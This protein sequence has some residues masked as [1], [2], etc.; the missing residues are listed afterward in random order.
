[1]SLKVKRVIKIISLLLLVF[2]ICI[3]SLA[4][5]RYSDFKKTLIVKIAN[6]ATSFIGQKVEIGDISFSTAGIN[7]YDISVKNPEEFIS[8]ELLRIKKLYLDMKYSD[9]VSRK[10]YFKKI[11]VYSPELTILRDQRGRM[12]ISE[13]LKDFFKRKPT[14]TYQIDELEMRSGSFDVNRVFRNENINIH[15]K[16]LS[17]NAG[18][19]TT[20]KGS[21]S[22]AGGNKIDFDGWAY[23]KD[24]PKRL[25]I[26]VSS[27]DI[28]LSPFKELLNKYR[29]NTE[30]TKSG[31]HLNIWGD[32]A[33]GLHIKSE[34]RI[35]E[36]GGSF[37]RRDA[38]EILLN[39][40][41]FFNIPDNLLS[42]EDC[43][44]HSDLLTV[45]TLKGEIKREEKDFVF[46]IL[47]KISKLDL[48]AFNFMKN[49]QVNG[50]I[51]SENLFIH[52][53]IK[54]HFP[55][56]SGTIKLRDG[57]F[58][59]KE[60]DI[61]AINA[62]LTF[63]PGRKMTAKAEAT[64][65][66]SRLKGY[67][68]NTSADANLQ[69]TATGDLKDIVFA[70]YINLS[71]VAIDIQK[72][73]KVHAESL[74]LNVKGNIKAK[75][76]SGESLV[77]IKV[78][79]YNK[80][81]IPRLHTKFLIK[82][83]GDDIA[84]KTLSMEGED[85]RVSSEL[86]TVSL[87]EREKKDKV[88]IKIEKLNASH[89]GKKA[90]IRDTDLRL[91]ISRGSDLIAGDLDFSIG[92][93]AFSGLHTGI[94]KGSGK[95]DNKNF[96]LKIPVAEVFHGKVRLTLQGRM[97][98]GPFPIKIVSNAEDIDLGKLS[99]E[100]MKITGMPYTVSGDLKSVVLE[101]TLQNTGSVEGSGKIEAENIAVLDKSIRTILRDVSLKG[102]IEF[103]GDDLDFNIDASDGKLS[104]DISGTVKKFAQKDRLLEMK[105]IQ[106]EVKLTDIRETFWEV[107]PYNLLYSGLGGFLSSDISVQ[108]TGASLQVNGRLTLK[109]IVLEGENR[110]YFIGPVDGVLPI[111]YKKPYGKVPK[112]M[113]L[114]E[115]SEFKNLNEYFSR[116][117][118]D[119]GY[120]KITIGSLMY[121][122]KLFDNIALWVKQEGNIF[123]VDRFSTDIFGGTMHGT[124]VFDISNSYNYRVGAI[125]KGLSLSTLCEEITPIRGYLSGMVDGLIHLKGTRGGIPQ[126]IGKADFWTYSTDEE[127]TKLSREFLQKVSGQSLKTY[128]RDRDFDK[129]IM[130]LYLQ[131]G[132]V[133]FHE[134]EISNRN[135]FGITDLS[136]K[137][138]PF[139]N[140]IAI[141]DLMWTITEAA[142]RAKKDK[143][144]N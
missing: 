103:K 142:N 105:I 41:A 55:E 98:E 121:G 92:G 5:L 50:M 79:Q 130:R 17:S 56:I 86:V 139:N 42:I 100:A 74:A 78:A 3:I 30:K 108:Y 28:T 125:L 43:S 49:V 120:S 32:T 138:A 29:I 132:F 91:N 81:K 9:L 8:G 59:S 95:F 124:A 25:N 112:E 10:F 27:G 48:S 51:T 18:V 101:G 131:N 134:F 111:A 83:S 115:R 52:G 73:K 118:S 58:K 26:S 126:I 85:F 133:V 69:V 53:S 96:S 60:T 35:K 143:E 36:V 102:G 33:K 75:I 24:D 107:F 21:T 47:P 14:V 45:A 7:I 144:G 2:I 37:F 31:F 117:I 39:V 80:Y 127:E 38:K 89:S 12:N 93:I 114:L 22:F 64:A 34:I 46:T 20:I 44:L 88:T 23:L 54:K 109:D 94:I 6:E 135:F 57:V 15:I 19:R 97:P 76:F 129:G 16:N 71:S 77:D 72:E 63:L 136:I 4:Y 110:E 11:T 123:T 137:V 99:V 68:L 119:S 84:L 62:K 40:S 82:Y 61:G 122:F 1:M 87:P 67:S 141:D 128:I 90:E 70:S 113:P 65:K 116:E 104:A 106:P 140:R 66:I 13:K